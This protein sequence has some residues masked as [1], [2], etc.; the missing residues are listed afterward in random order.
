M[1]Q[2]KKTKA[3]LLIDEAIKRSIEIK[4]DILAKNKIVY[5]DVRGTTNGPEPERTDR[6]DGSQ[7]G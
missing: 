1:E 7:Q 5:K 2:T 4:K 3:K 6:M